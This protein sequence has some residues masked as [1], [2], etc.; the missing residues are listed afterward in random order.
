MNEL[1]KHFPEQTQEELTVLLKL[2][3]QHV[4]GSNMIILFGSYARGTYVLWDER[5]EFGVHTSYQIDY[6]ILV[7]FSKSNAEIIEKKLR[8]DVLDAYHKCFVGKRHATPRFIVENISI[9]NKSLECS[10]YFF[11]DIAKEGIVLYNDRGHRLSLPRQLDYKEI[12][13]TSYTEFNNH[14]PSAVS[15][16]E[17]VSSYF[18]V[19][20][21]YTNS[22]FLLHQACERFYYAIL[23]VWTNYLPKNHKLIELGAMVKSF[24]RELSYVFPQN[25]ALEV[26]SYDLLRRAYI[27]ARYNNKNFKISVEQLNY[28]ISRLEYLSEITNRLCHEKLAFYDEMIASGTTTLLYPDFEEGQSHAAEEED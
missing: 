28:L 25:T 14:Y 4:S 21:D 3:R 1:I 8:F 11:T 6:D 12:R 5:F 2:I 27:E 22:A 26:T 16:L 10:Q 20:G 18:M 13:E 15:L 7:V 24:S 23:L 9:L 17:S 19:K